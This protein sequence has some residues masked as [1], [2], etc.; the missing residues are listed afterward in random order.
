MTMYSTGLRGSCARYAVVGAG[1][2]AALV[3][4]LLAAGQS[5]ACEGRNVIFEDDFTSDL[6]RWNPDPALTFGGSGGKVSFASHWEHFQIINLAASPLDGDVCMTATF[7]LKAKNT[8]AVAI[9]F[10]ITDGANY[11]M[12]QITQER[13]VILWRTYF[14]IR[15]A[16]WEEEILQTNTA[17]GASNTVRV[18]TKGKSVLAY[19]NGA[20]VREISLQPPT[21]EVRFGFHLQL[22]EETMG[23]DE[24]V[25]F[26]TRYKM[27]SAD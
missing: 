22:N 26:I 2:I 16:L 14:G 6:G 11:Y 20:R 10:W 15:L 7:P 9:R 13:K 21:G 3:V 8:A 18:V 17:P 12:L 5:L 23:P 24:R 1:A 4:G 19:I 27:T 25:F